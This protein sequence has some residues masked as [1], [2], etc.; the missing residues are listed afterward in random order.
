MECIFED[1]TDTAPNR[2]LVQTP[3]VVIVHYIRWSIYLSNSEPPR[4][5]LPLPLLRTGEE[6]I[7][8]GLIR[9][10]WSTGEGFICTFLALRYAVTMPSSG[11]SDQAHVVEVSNPLPRLIVHLRPDT[12]SPLHAMARRCV[13]YGFCFFCPLRYFAGSFCLN[14]AS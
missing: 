9:N 5:P 2:N 3:T 7:Q 14:T 11:A 13:V 6:E 1:I 4:P 10:R 8:G 12:G